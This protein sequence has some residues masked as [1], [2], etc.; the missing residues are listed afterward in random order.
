MLGRDDR[1]FR[2]STCTSPKITGHAK[3]LGH[4]VLLDRQDPKTKQVGFGS[5]DRDSSKSEGRCCSG[6]CY[7]PN[8]SNADKKLGK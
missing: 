6:F 1:D 3:M 2:I 5:S 7:G 4:P 8:F